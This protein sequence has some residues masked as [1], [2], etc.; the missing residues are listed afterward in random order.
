ML[1]TELRKWRRIGRSVGRCQLM[2]RKLSG[3]NFCIVER[4]CQTPSN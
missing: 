2:P 1:K 3:P 4:L